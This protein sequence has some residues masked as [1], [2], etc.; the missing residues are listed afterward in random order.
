MSTARITLDN[1]VFSGRLRQYGRGTPF[2]H[3]PARVVPRGISDIYVAPAKKQV[4]ANVQPVVVPGRQ[5]RSQVLQRNVMPAPVVSKRKTRAKKAT[6]QKLMMAMA[7]IIFVVGL[8]VAAMGLRTNQAVIAQTRQATGANGG[9]AGQRA[10]VSEEKPSAAA[11]SSYRVDKMAPRIVSIPKLKVNARIQAQGTEPNG[12]L[13]APY[14]VHDAGWFDQSGKPGEG[15]AI[16]LDG[17][18]AGPTVHGVFYDIKKLVAGDRISI[19]R[20]DGKKFQYKVVKTKT[21]KVKDVD[22][23][24]ALLPAVEGASGLNMITCTGNY[25]H[26]TG[27]Y[28]QR[29]MVFAVEV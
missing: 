13:K 7:G 11:I 18:V 10:V 20:G 14:N 9:A 3:Q 12:A 8:G 2:I 16:L 27:E 26:K 15:G 25:D 4:R 24:A 19:E 29:V 1:P 6:S 22:M 23:S 17:H 28:D 5:E 21:A